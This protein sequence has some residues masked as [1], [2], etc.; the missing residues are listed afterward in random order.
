MSG[1]NDIVLLYNFIN[2]HLSVLF[3]LTKLLEN[4][5]FN[6]VWCFSTESSNFWAANLI[7][8]WGQKPAD[9]LLNV[10]KVSWYML[11]LYRWGLWSHI[12]WALLTKWSLNTELKNKQ[13]K[14][15][16]AN[17]H[18]I[19]CS[20]VICS[21]VWQCCCLWPASFPNLSPS[22]QWH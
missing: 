3:S 2:P 8:E 4:S 14:R 19:F 7:C 22:A 11:S 1:T 5:H 15:Q 16:C 12:S 6:I 13:T 10:G 18:I 21:L 20:L 9:H 17:I